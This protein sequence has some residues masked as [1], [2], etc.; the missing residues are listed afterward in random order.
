[1]ISHLTPERTGCHE[2]RNQYLRHGGKH[3]G[4]FKYWPQVYEQWW[5]KEFPHQADLFM[6]NAKV[7]AETPTAAEMQYYCT[8]RK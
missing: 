7:W 4:E 2:C 5:K 1:M 3:R 8:R 6:K